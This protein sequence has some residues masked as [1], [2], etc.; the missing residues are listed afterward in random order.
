MSLFKYI[1]LHD[2][3]VWKSILLNGLIRFTQAGDFN[4]PFEL[5]TYFPDFCSEEKLHEMALEHCRSI[6]GTRYD[7][8]PDWGKKRTTREDFIE[9]WIALADDEVANF[10]KRH[11]EDMPRW[12]LDFFRNIFR[13]AQDNFG[14]LCVT[15]KPDNL[16]MWAHY[17]EQ[18][19]GVV[20]EFDDRHK[21]FNE[22]DTDGH[23]TFGIIK[24]VQYTAERPIDD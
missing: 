1:S 19:K 13:E 14:I 12:Q 10:K 24:K 22:P 7:S 15:E 3:V 2:D 18:H 21:F 23:Q 9:T 20:I 4:D 6:A 11:R 8:A 16:L 17:G 5:P